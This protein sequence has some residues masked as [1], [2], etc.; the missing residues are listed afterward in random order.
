MLTCSTMTRSLAGSTKSTFPRLPFSRPAM[1]RTV[2]FFRI[3]SALPFIAASDDLGRERDD[4]Q[5]LPVPQL[6]RHGPEDPRPDRVVLGVQEHR[7]VP[8]ELDV[9]PVGPTDLLRR[10]HHDRPGDVALLDRAV[11]R[12]FL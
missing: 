7:G 2:S 6:A 1:T 8:V 12:R 10:P 4:L 5:E 9:R 3:A 11:R